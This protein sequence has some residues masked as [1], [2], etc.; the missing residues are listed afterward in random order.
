MNVEEINVLLDRVE[1]VLRSQNK[2]EAEFLIKDLEA[3]LPLVKNQEAINY[4]NN[5]IAQLLIL[6]KKDAE[7]LCYFE[8]L[9]AQDKSYKYNYTG[10][11]E[12]ALCLMRLG[13]KSE[14]L[15]AF[16]DTFSLAKKNDDYEG[17]A[18]AA[19]FISIYFYE[20]QDYEQALSYLNEV[21][22]YAK[23]IYN[24]SLESESLYRIGCIHLFNEKYY[25]AIDCFREAED[26]AV[27]CRDLFLIYQAA[28]KRCFLYL[29]LEKTNQAHKIIRN[30][31]HLNEPHKI[32]KP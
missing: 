29:K 22:H 8:A 17:A 32:D 16:F 28:V 21:I 3:A 15:S 24:K 10:F 9:I 7:A 27:D 1:T 20:L 19:R 31:V 26:L 25:I 11:L 6:L 13:S 2:I 23:K 12:K 5:Y 30:L 4:I 14:G 18:K